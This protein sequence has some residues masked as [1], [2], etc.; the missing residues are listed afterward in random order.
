MG[1]FT[2]SLS[3]KVATIAATGLWLVVV[4]VS[5][6]PQAS[7]APPPAAPVTA[8]STPVEKTPPS[9]VQAGGFVGDDT[10][11]TCHEDKKKGY[12]GRRTPVRR[13]SVRRRGATAAK[14]VTAPAQAH[15]DAGMTET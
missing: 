10:C 12:T 4:S 6:T 15:V 8:P 9:N 14:A 3:P 5:A 2:R 13:T 1:R 7:Q 11:L